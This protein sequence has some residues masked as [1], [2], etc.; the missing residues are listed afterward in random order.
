MTLPLG[1][2]LVNELILDTH[3]LSEED[4]V[5]LHRAY[6][7]EVL[8]ADAALGVFFTE[9][10]RRK[11]W[12]ETRLVVTSDHGEEFWEHGRYEHG[13]STRSVVTQVPLLLKADGVV[14]GR[15]DSVVDLTLLPAAL[16]DTPESQLNRIARSG[17]LEPGDTGS[18][19]EIRKPRKNS[20]NQSR[21]QGSNR[22]KK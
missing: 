21:R 7:E 3:P 14:P 19:K 16:L 10:K 20:R 6:D 15:N 11:G 9:L 2:D 17:T 1:D 12:N 18:P 5:Y 4:Q 22:N 13:H 8:T